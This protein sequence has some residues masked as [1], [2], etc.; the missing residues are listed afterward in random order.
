MILIRTNHHCLRVGRHTR[1]IW[2]S[3]KNPH[4]KEGNTNFTGLNHM[5]G[6]SQVTHNRL[7]EQIP[8]VICTREIVNTGGE[9][10]LLWMEWLTQMK[11]QILYQI[12][13]NV[14]WSLGESCGAQDILFGVLSQC[15]VWATRYVREGGLYLYSR[16]NFSHWS[17]DSQTSPLKN[18]TSPMDPTN[19]KLT[20]DKPWCIPLPS[21]TFTLNQY[22][23]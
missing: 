2:F 18:W 14:D 8:R 20:E 15:M 5:L 13:Q 10:V 19:I 21:L 16:L 11:A 9:A 17:K 12:L 1:S 6:S 3:T 4:E 23:C 22:L 7:G